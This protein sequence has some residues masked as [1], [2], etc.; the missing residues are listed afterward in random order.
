[1]TE[2]Q[3]WS[4]SEAAEMLRQRGPVIVIVAVIFALTGYL[5]SFGFSPGKLIDKLYRAADRRHEVAHATLPTSLASPQTPVAGS[6]ELAAAKRALDESTAKLEA[7]KQSHAQILSGDSDLQA[8]AAVKAKLEDDR[9]AIEQARDDKAY[10]QSLLAQQLSGGTG[11]AK[12]SVASSSSVESLEVRQLRFQISKYDD[13]IANATRDQKRLQKQLGAK[14][15][16]DAEAQQHYNQLT[17]DQEESRKTYAILLAR[18]TAEEPEGEPAGRSAEAAAAQPDSQPSESPNRSWWFA[19][20]GLAGG[21]AA[22]I[23]VAVWLGMRNKTIRTAQDV[24]TILQAPLLV[25]VPWIGRR[26]V[27]NNGK[28]PPVQASADRTKLEKDTIEV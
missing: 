25:S 18:S 27:S 4:A 28:N 12:L 11:S 23:G 26:E 2:G 1:M 20:A 21:L 14:G 5:A 7:F 13:Q 22:G 19:G 16:L 10:T 17:H 3:N 9:R 6:P 8:R 15:Q 24:Q